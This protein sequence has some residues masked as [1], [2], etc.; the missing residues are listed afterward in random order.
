MSKLKISS[1]GRTITVR[2][3]TS[4]RR[5]GGR[6]VVLFPNGTDRSIN[7]LHSQQRAINAIGKAIARAYRWRALLESGAHSTIAELAEAEKINT[8]YVSRVLRL[9]LLAPDIV[10]QLLNGRSTSVITLARLLKG[11]PLNWNIQRQELGLTEV[12]AS[13]SP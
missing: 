9:T 12:V 6:K 1:D 11:F 13:S 2:V 4:I 3:P 8:V 5:R 10:E 7:R